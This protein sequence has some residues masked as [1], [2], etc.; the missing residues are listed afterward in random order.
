MAR[1][2]LHNADNGICQDLWTYILL[3]KH[4]YREKNTKIILNS[5]DTSCYM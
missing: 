2:L 5:M 4:T 1:T 3:Q